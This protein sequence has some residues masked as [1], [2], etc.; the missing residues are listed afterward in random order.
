MFRLILI[1]VLISPLC[2]CSGP[3]IHDPELPELSADGYRYP[4]QVLHRL[5][6]AASIPWFHD[7]TGCP[8]DRSQATRI[9]DHALSQWNIP[10]TVEFEPA[11]SVEEAT[12][13]VLWQARG[14]RGGARFG[15]SES[16][17]AQVV[18]PQGS[19]RMQI[20]LNSSL[21][22]DL[23]PP[24]IAS[25]K[26]T[27]I[28]PDGQPRFPELPQPNLQLV[29]VHEGGHVLGLGHV[30]LEDSV[31]QP[32]QGHTISQP[33]EGDFAGIRSLYGDGSPAS[34]GD[35]Q[36]LCHDPEGN[37]FLAAPI[38]RSIAPQDRVRVYVVDLDGDEQDELLLLQSAQSWTPGSGL[39]IIGFDER[40]LLKK[41]YGPLP[42]AVDG[43]TVVSYGRTSSGD[44]V[45]A[46]PTIGDK[47]SGLV[48]KGGRLPVRP[49]T[50]GTAWEAIKGGGGD[51]DGDGILDQ[52]IYGLEPLGNCDL[53]GDGHREF[54]KLGDR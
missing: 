44:G 6:G 50:V 39:L 13:V 11:A 1:L 43:S 32:L 49:W 2:A 17:L 5:K 7:D 10:G 53:D 19:D 20:V 52:P 23:N 28:G 54:L 29:V 21:A 9:I 25:E 41:T 46:I 35:L 38:V 3:Q 45:L 33:S 14:V 31:M 24:A 40:S 47:Y 36:I 15:N 27:S 4:Y 18:K 51:Q 42:A 48:F 37:E 22:W 34:T 16:I 26:Q 8:V 30:D 12:V